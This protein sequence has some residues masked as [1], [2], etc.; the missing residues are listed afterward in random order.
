[1]LIGEIV[2]TGFKRRITINQSFW[3]LQRPCPVPS[4][5]LVLSI[6]VRIFSKITV[7]ENYSR[8]QIITYFQRSCYMTHMLLV[9]IVYFQVYLWSSIYYLKGS[10]D[11]NRTGITE[12]IEPLDRKR[13]KT[14]WKSRINKDRSISGPGG[15]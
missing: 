4:P 7:L 5:V 2:S 8:D 3:K 10:T 14:F 15:L 9:K 1:M 11:Q 13:T 6:F 12:K